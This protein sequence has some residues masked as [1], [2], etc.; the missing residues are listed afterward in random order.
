M[1]RPR[2]TK[3]LQ[4]DIVHRSKMNTVFK[5]TRF[6]RAN[7][8]NVI[9]RYVC[10]CV[11][12]DSLKSNAPFRFAAD[13]I[14]LNASIATTISRLMYILLYTYSLLNRLKRGPHVCVILEVHVIQRS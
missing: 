3:R 14:K 4:T 13:S 6:A 12:C 9:Y 2:S 5:A 7:I 10:D 11:C 1:S 8:Y